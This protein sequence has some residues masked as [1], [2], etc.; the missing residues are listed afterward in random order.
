MLQTFVDACNIITM[1][2]NAEVS[3]AVY[4]C[5]GNFIIYQWLCF[6]Y[7]GNYGKSMMKFEVH[8]TKHYIITL[9]WLYI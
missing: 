1:Y 6:D 8:V 9:K 5:H 4:S 7:Q 2:G 3:P